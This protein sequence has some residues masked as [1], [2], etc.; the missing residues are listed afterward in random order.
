MSTEIL[1]VRV[2]KE[3]K[4]EVEKLKLD[5]RSILENALIAALKQEKKKRLEKTVND[6]LLEMEKVS[7]SDWVRAVKE[8]R[9]ER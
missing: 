2:K 5:V 8:C 6:L 7:E 4:R 3:L 1:S 9:K